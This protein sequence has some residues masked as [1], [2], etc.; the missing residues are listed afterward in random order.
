VQGLAL[1]NI[2]DPDN[3][4]HPYRIIAGDYPNW[5]SQPMPQGFGWY[6]K[7]WYPRALLAGVMP[8]DRAFEREMRKMYAQAIP[9]DKQ[10]VYAQTQLPDMDFRFFNGASQGLVYP[11]L[12]GNEHVFLTNLTVEGD[13]KFQLPGDTP[14]MTI[15]IGSGAIRPDVVMHTLVI[16]PDD[17][18][19][20]I[21]WRG[22]IP[23]AGPD[24]LP[25]MRKLSVEI[26]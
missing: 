26:A 7:Y 22:S 23:Y 20:D 4:L 21:T 8:A 5:E 11:Y 12:T 1:P 19:L 9:A 3:L 13:L 24:W 17:G 6:C 2:E 25:R 16:R 10:G 18:K 15:D 14:R